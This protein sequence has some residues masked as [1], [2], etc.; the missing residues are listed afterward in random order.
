MDSGFLCSVGTYFHVFCVFQDH[1]VW[2]EDICENTHECVFYVS[3]HMIDGKEEP[4]VDSE[5]IINYECKPGRE[6]SPIISI[7]FVT[8]SD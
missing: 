6:H 2:E 3:P 5:V 8:I 1:C 4:T 7:M